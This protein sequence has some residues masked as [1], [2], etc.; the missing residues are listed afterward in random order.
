ML[1]WL[2]TCRLVPVAIFKQMLLSTGQMQHSIQTIALVLIH[3]HF[4]F[5][6]FW[7]SHADLKFGG[8]SLGYCFQEGAD[9]W[10]PGAEGRALLSALPW[11]DG[12]PHLWSLSETH[13][14]TCGQCHGQAVA[15]GGEMLENSQFWSDFSVEVQD[16]ICWGIFWGNVIAFFYQFSPQSLLSPVLHLF[17]LSSTMSSSS[18]TLPSRVHV[19]PRV[20]CVRAPLSGPPVLRA[21]GSRLLWKAFWHGEGFH[22]GPAGDCCPCASSLPEK[23]QPQHEADTLI[24]P[25]RSLT[26]S[27][28]R[29]VF[30][31]LHLDPLSAV[32]FV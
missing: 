32:F 9:V 24:S 2:H 7:G 13:W 6:I 15:R 23:L 26:F 14:R 3:S 18:P 25:Q 31:H 17:F 27:P 11:Q 28:H 1:G 8:W 4:F 16:Y 10:C 22:G 29:S 21:R 19:A 30:Q 20:H 5:L 12:R